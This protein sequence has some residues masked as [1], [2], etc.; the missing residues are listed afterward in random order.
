MSVSLSGE[1]E[2]AKFSRS[3]FLTALASLPIAVPAAAQ[4][5]PK[6]AMH[7][8]AVI[9]TNKGTI[10]IK[11]YPEEAPKSVENFI[12]LAKKGYYDGQMWHRVEPGFVIQ[13]GDPQSKTLKPGDERLGTGGPGYTIPDEK[14]KILKHNRG[15]VGMAKSSAPNSGGSQFYICITKPAPN[16][17]G[18]YT[19][20]GQVISGQD[21]AEKIEVGDRMKKVTIMEPKGK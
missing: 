11:F 17:D 10:K 9:E 13:T 2:L 14:N 12:K 3:A 6:R 4:N 5:A 8:I 1:Y 18:G 21:V 16:L 20:F 15:A 7:P 19:V